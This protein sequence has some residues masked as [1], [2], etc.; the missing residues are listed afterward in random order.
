M[1]RRWVNIG[2][3]A[4]LILKG[5]ARKMAVTDPARFDSSTVLTFLPEPDT[6]V[7]V[8]GDSAGAKGFGQ[9]TG[10]VSDEEEKKDRSI[11]GAFRWGVLSIPLSPCHLT[12]IPLIV[13]FISG[14]YLII[15]SA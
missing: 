3:L 8:N 6:Q 7:V 10:S 15:L 1:E 11:G 4:M 5:R 2:V 13:G 12:S 14:V 9:N